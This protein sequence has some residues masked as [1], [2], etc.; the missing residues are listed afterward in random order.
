[1]I[2]AS[3]ILGSY[4]RYVG[5]SERTREAVDTFWRMIAFLANA[6]LFLLVGTQLNLFQFLASS[7][8]PFSLVLTAVLAI[9]AVLLARFVMVGMLRGLALLRPLG[10]KIILSWRFIIFWSGLRGA[11]SLALVLALPLEVPT[12]DAL[13]F[14]TYAVVLF[15][16]IV[17][18]FRLR[19]ILRRLPAVAATD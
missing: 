4:G 11:L 15:T 8:S 9:V 1:V 12:R 3:L 10:G 16:L 14:S 5:M 18:G 2:V 6:L 7:H 13:I 19:S 17:Q